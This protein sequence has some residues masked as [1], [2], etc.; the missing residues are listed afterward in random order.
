MTATPPFVDFLND[1]RPET[2]KILV[3]LRF[4]VS[5]LTDD[6]LPHELREEMDASIDDR[7]TL[8]IPLRELERDRER[9]VQGALAFFSDRWEDPRERDRIIR[10]FDGAAT[11]LPVIEAGLIAMTS[12]YAMYLLTTGGRKKSTSTIEHRADGSF[13]EKKTEEWFAP[14]GPLQAIVALFT[15]RA[16]RK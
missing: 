2:E 3:A 1:R 9:Q 10:A 14:T 11:K 6:K 12:M 16:A 5:E 4:Y 15:G 7:R 8:D 13:V